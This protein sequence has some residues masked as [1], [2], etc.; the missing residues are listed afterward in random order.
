MTRADGDRPPAMIA[1]VAA[2]C[3]SRKY[4]YMTHEVEHPGWGR[5]ILTTANGVTG[6][7]ARL[8]FVLLRRGWNV[9]DIQI[10]KDGEPQDVA[11]T[12]QAFMRALFADA[13]STS[14]PSRTGGASQPRNGALETKK[15]T[16]LRV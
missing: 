7:G 12:V 3:R 4:H 9:S 14:T 11:K 8:T 15:N 1:H 5:Y 16:V 2:M 6:M 10:V 13:D